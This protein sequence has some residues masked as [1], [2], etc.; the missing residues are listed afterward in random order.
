[1]L[2]S[3][4][5]QNEFGKLVRYLTSVRRALIKTCLTVLCDL[6]LFA[7]WHLGDVQLSL[8]NLRHKRKG[9]QVF[10]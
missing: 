3:F 8:W 7:L 2:V 9:T 1:M 6:H 10:I 5:R 4:N